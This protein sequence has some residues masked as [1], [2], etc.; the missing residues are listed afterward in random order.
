MSL[1][2]FGVGLTN[3]VVRNGYEE[4]ENKK[5]CQLI[6]QNT[7]FFS[8]FS[9]FSVI[10]VTLGKLLSNTTKSCYPEWL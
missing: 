4:S 3:G 8:I 6:E 9:C 10:P 5:S 7:T 2:V 1:I